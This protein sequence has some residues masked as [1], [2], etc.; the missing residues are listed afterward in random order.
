MLYDNKDSSE[1][2][3]V[4]PDCKKYYDN[5]GQGIVQLK[6]G[7]HDIHVVSRTGELI[8]CDLCVLFTG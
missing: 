8:L 7:D 6:K 2:F 5:K 3:G 4:C 1:G